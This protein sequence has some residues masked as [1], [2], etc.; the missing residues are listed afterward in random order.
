VVILEGFKMAK[1]IIEGG[2][3][4][5]GEVKISGS[6]NASL[7]IMAATLL[8]DGECFL[9][10]VP[11]VWDVR[12]M[13]FVLRTLGM[14]VEE[15]DG[16]F[17]IIP[18]KMLHY[19]A[20]YELVRTMR[21]SVL[22][23]GPLLARLRHARVSMPGGCAIGVRPV[24]LHLKGLARM[25]AEISIKEGYIEAHAK[26]GLKGARICFEKKSV[27]ATEN[28]IM[29][30]ALAKGKTYVEN[31]AMEPE[32][33]DLAGFLNRMGAKIKN[34]GPGCLE[35][36]GVEKLKGT[37]YRVIP[38]RIET[39]TFL[40]A[41]A[42]AGGE[43]TLKDVRTDHV[44]IITDKL[45][46]MGTSV[47]I[48]KNSMTV[49]GKKRLKGAEIDTDPFPG[50]PTDLQPQMMSLLCVCRGKSVVRETIFE[51]RFMHIG[52]LQRMGARVEIR[53]NSAVIT[54]V[55]Y[56][57][58]TSVMASDIRCGAALVVAGLEARGETC[59]SR[60][61]HIDRG[62][63]KIED[64]FKSLGARIKRTS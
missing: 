34:T 33:T 12:S 13:G 60:I 47:D 51:N 43:V 1:L 30:A 4:L 40:I 3:P 22:V 23:L 39:G 16:R 63:E 14:R 49:S 31:A 20:P 27:G 55:E 57:N 25:G 6:K 59:I 10:N 58:G 19:E 8:A 62:Y 44:K 38:D 35:I 11:K 56:L 29:A 9:D 46:K 15:Q 18:P 7:P 54:G 50:F 5:E 17:K 64:K 42:A 61:Y 45:K 2:K 21:A 24:D 48:K 26:G 53:G 52:E 28:I 32:I 41:G 37:F 36:T